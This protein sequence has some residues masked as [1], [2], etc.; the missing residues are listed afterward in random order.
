MDFLRAY[1]FSQ[2]R[3]FSLVP[4]CI[5]CLRQRLTHSKCSRHLG[6]REE[7]YNMEPPKHPLTLFLNKLVCSKNLYQEFAVEN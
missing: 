2:G 1:G 5:P 3:D 7:F 4:G 6:G